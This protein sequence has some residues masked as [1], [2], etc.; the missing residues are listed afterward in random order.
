[1]VKA[2]THGAN[3]LERGPSCVEKLVIDL[4][5]TARVGFVSSWNRVE[6]RKKRATHPIAEHDHRRIDAFDVGQHPFP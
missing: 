5:V 6:R 1:M 4:N 3:D 2:D